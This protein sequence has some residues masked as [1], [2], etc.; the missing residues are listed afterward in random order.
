MFQIDD[1]A[2][3]VLTNCNIADS[4]HAGLYSVCGLALRLRD[5]YK[6]ENRL[7]PW[8][9]NDPSEILKWI[10]D[11]EEAWEKLAEKKFG[12]ILLFG[13]RFDP[14]DVKGING[15][16]ESYGLI[17][18]GGY[19]RSL[20]PSF[21]LA[22]LEA[23]K[24]INHISVFILGREFARDLLTI[25]ALSQDNCIYIRKE[26]ARLFLWDQIFYVKKSGRYALNFGLEVYGLKDD[27]PEDL[28]RNLSTIAANETDTYIYHELGEIQDSVFDRNTWQE[29]IAA[30]PHTPIE[31]LTRTVKDLL[32]DTSEYG[33]L[34][35]I[36]RERKTASL[37]FYV[38]FLESFTQLLFTQIIEAFQKFT[39]TRDWELIEQA[40]TEGYKNA[41]SGAEA[42]AGIY[43]LGREKNDMK[44]VENEMAKRF[45]S[46][47]NR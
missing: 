46:C 35:H 3:Q 8:I 27:T 20:K 31:L 9:E 1:I 24:E 17:Y 44:W 36:I 38:A 22:A 26:S 34:Q 28:H 29:I 30:F 25:P 15:V 18:G 39:Q 40:V 37:A 2:D 4:R 42:I 19:A 6:W 16:L 41:K 12:D 33:T 13:R 21:F 10:G 23:K 5:L 32:A 7:D 43:R 11:K 45:K 47:F 14:F